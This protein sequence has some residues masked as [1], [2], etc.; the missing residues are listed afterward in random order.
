MSL[1]F[2]CESS[3]GKSNWVISAWW[4]TRLLPQPCSAWYA[5]SSCFTRVEQL[6]DSLFL[7]LRCVYAS[8]TSIKPNPAYSQLFYLNI[9]RKVFFAL[10][11]MIILRKCC[12]S[13]RSI[14]FIFCIDLAHRGQTNSVA[15][16]FI[17]LSSPQIQSFSE[18][19]S[20][21]CKQGTTV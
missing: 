18:S 8:L 4:R 14:Y 7:S 17:F 2:R 9:H 15:Y 13:L 16:D 12:E 11:H 3:V 20:V 19:W 21:I 6:S 10:F 1:G 5:A